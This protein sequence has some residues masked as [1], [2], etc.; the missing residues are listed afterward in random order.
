MRRTQAILV[1]VALLA[2]PLGLLARSQACGPRA[3]CVK[4]CCPPHAAPKPTG[5]GLACHHGSAPARDCMMKSAGNHALDF[6]F[7]SPLPPIVLAAAEVI[8][9]PDATT[10]N[11][12]SLHADPLAGFTAAPF[13]PPRL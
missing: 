7:A 4:V 3:C 8:G 9:K 6:G 5:H 10:A 1:V 12:P 13:E 11:L 2:A